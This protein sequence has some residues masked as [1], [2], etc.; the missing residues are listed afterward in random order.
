MAASR[1]YKLS[2][3]TVKRTGRIDTPIP[4]QGDRKGSLLSRRLQETGKEI[5]NKSE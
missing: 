2:R 1:L 4:I 3:V 5:S